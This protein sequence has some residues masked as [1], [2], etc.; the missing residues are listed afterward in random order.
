MRKGICRKMERM[1]TMA[2]CVIAGLV[3]GGCGDDG[4]GTSSASAE[5]TVLIYA[6]GSDLS[7]NAE[8]DVNDI[9]K[10]ST[11]NQVNIVVAAGGGVPIEH[12]SSDS[13][14]LDWTQLTHL[15][16]GRD[17]ALYRSVLG[18][19]NMGDGAT[20]TSFVK[21]AVKTYPAKNYSIIF[22]DHGGGPIGGFGSDSVFRTDA[23]QASLSIA[24][25]AESM[26]TIQAD[27]GVTFDMVGFDAC[28]MASA[29]IANA[30]SPYARYLVAS[31]DLEFGSWDYDN[32]L[33]AVSKNPAID[34]REFGEV[35]ID[36]ARQNNNGTSGENN[37]ALTLSMIDLTKMG[38]VVDAIDNLGGEL[39]ASL[40]RDP[41]PPATPPADVATGNLCTTN[42]SCIAQARHGAEQFD[43]D[44]RSVAPDTVDLV[45]FAQSLVTFN[46][47]HTGPV[48]A[49][50]EAI[51][52]V[53]AA[54]ADA[55]IDQA[56]GSE[57]TESS[58]LTIYV[59]ASTIYSTTAGPAYSSLSFSASYKAFVAGYTA[60]APGV[61]SDASAF[62]KGQPLNSG[63]VLTIAQPLSS[64]LW[65]DAMPLAA[66]VD[67]T[68]NAAAIAPATTVNNA[69]QISAD[70]TLR[71]FVM[72]GN[73]VSVVPAEAPSAGSTYI[74]PVCYKP[75][76]NATVSGG[77]LV[78][79]VTGDSVSLTSG[80]PILTYDTS[81]AGLY[82][83]QPS[84]QIASRPYSY[85]STDKR[86]DW[87]DC[88]TLDSAR[89]TNWGS[90]GPT[91]SASTIANGTSVMLGFMDISDFFYFSA[92]T[93]LTWQ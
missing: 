13:V 22:D 27:T 82:Q 2:M 53:K 1:R 51:Q 32:I 68:G 9:L 74:V 93:P 25:I 61:M 69:T 29:E 60:M 64:A 18:K 38:A 75:V 28:L 46:P 6:V 62:S 37:P 36:A 43:N 5:R 34:G 3:M 16:K 88:S 57:R 65:L 19:E 77:Y 23:D 10:N 79:T 49:T 7:T 76:R 24:T 4:D 91:F 67:P 47:G 39:T 84:D 86:W 52:R 20:F 44:F 45:S 14:Q 89:Y 8:R 87:A 35:V 56:T 73:P 80:R 12:D 66:I 26:K 70:R 50:P 78:A 55:V 31:E 41:S 90:T 48:P 42:W 92:G 85:S 59:P 40:A 83:A 17:G 71:R 63:G 30:I 15:A 11:S 21:W 33:K 81:A 58:G 54:V 72:N